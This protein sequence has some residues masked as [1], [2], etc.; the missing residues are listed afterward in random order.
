M[1]AFLRSIDEWTYLFSV[2]ST[3]EWPSI[4]ESVFTSKPN[5]MQ[6]V[7]N[8]CLRAWKLI[9]GKSAFFKNI[10]NRCCNTLGS[11]GTSLLD[12]TK[13]EFI[14]LHRK[15]ISDTILGI[16]MIL[17]E[18]LLFGVPTVTFVELPLYILCTVL[19]IERV[20][21]LKSISSHFKPH[22]S[23]IRNPV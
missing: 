16:G 10:L 23:P 4:S 11:T 3:D 18:L 6:L 5:F 19:L 21:A 15:S 1:Q 14:L 20:F 12:N 8:I 17:T 22:T 2:T 9:D 7:A 13:F